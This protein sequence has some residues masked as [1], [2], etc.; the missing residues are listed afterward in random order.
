MSEEKVVHESL[1]K[2]RLDHPASA[3]ERAYAAAWREENVKSWQ[4]GGPLLQVLLTV[5]PENPFAIFVDTEKRKRVYEV[6]QRDAH[7]A[8][9]VVQWLGTNIGR[10]FV[11]DIL[12]GEGFK[13]VKCDP[14]HLREADG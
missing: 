6:N 5:G 2:D 11:E 4:F 10:M 12:K 14:D 8:A 9:T 3:L 1:H 7:V 13:L